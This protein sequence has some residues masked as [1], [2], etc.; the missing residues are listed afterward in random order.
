M[1][2]TPEDCK[3]FMEMMI[4]DDGSLYDQD[5]DFNVHEDIVVLP[6]SSGTTGPAKGVSLTH[7]NMVAN[8]CQVSHPDIT[9]VRETSGKTR[10]EQESTVAIDPVHVFSSPPPPPSF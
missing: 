1:E 9:M 4:T 7:Y 5:R 6:Y 10:Q 3:S 8:M 2:E